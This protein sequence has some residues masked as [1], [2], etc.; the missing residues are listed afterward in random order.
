MK[1]KIANMHL[2]KVAEFIASLELSGKASRG[3]VKFGDVLGAKLQEFSKDF[4]DIQSS[5]KDESV[6]NDEIIELVKEESIIVLDEY[7]HL[8]EA[9]TEALDVYGETL[10]G[11]DAI[12]YD[13]LMT[14]FENAN[15]KV[16]VVN[17]D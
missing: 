8:I 1:I 14:A 16:E 3:K 9:F 6:R 11:D 17:H 5:D 15:K 2:K 4:N 13:V 10:K 7:E 12:A